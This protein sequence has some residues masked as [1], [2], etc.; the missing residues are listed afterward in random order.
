MQPSQNDAA[1]QTQPLDKFC[2]LADR[3]PNAPNRQYTDWDD[4]VFSSGNIKTDPNYKGGLIGFALVGDT[5]TEC[6]ATKYSQRELNQVCTNCTPNAPWVTTL[7]WQSTVDPE[8][9]YMGFEDL[10]MSLPRTG[11]SAAGSTRTTATSTTSSITSAASPAR[12][13][14]SAVTPASLVPARLAGPTVAPAPTWPVVP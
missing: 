6:K 4:A 10:A 2:P 8:G 7:I 13:A 9:F 11:M 3:A 1:P 5:T 12:V 14:A